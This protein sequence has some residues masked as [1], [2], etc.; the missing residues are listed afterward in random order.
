MIPMR[1]LCI[2][3]HF[4]SGGAQRQM[5]YLAKGLKSRGHDVEMLVYHTG[6]DFFRQEIVDSGI[7][8]WDCTSAQGWHLVLV[9]YYRLIRTGRFDAVISFLHT[10]N[11]LAEMGRIVNWKLPIVVSERSSR[12]EMASPLSRFTR[13]FMHIFANRVV[14]NSVDHSEWLRSFF[15]LRRKVTTIYNGYPHSPKVPFTPPDRFEDLK[16]LVIG[17]VGPE[18]NGLALIE[19]MELFRLR[20]GFVPKLTWVGRRDSSRSGKSYCDEIDKKL[21]DYP[22]IKAQWCW[23][24]ERADIPQII[25]DHHVLIHPSLYEGLPN[26]ICEAFIAG[27]PV[28]ASDVCDHPILVKDSER[29]YLF[30]PADPSDICKSIQKLGGLCPEAWARLSENCRTYTDE[31]L[32]LDRMVD[33]YE[34]LILSCKVGSK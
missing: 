19:A 10:P 7:Q 12:N 25:A 16:L 34:S 17:R 32:G 24:G 8:I 5:A 2:I 13:R 20:A 30:N 4:G 18:K 28:L 3:D 33:Q 21:S 27:R 23:L 1:I 11:F 6:H 9:T 29:G 26:V 22:A 31:V 14:S 15:W